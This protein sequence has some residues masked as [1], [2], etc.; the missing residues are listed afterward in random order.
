MAPPYT[1]APN[2][3][4]PQPVLPGPEIVK[5]DIATAAPLL[6]TT[7]LVACPLEYVPTLNIVGSVFRTAGAWM[8]VAA[9]PAPMIERFFE[10][11]S[12]SV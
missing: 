3:R 5:S 9:L 7:M 12:C 11:T 6:T 10:T 8:T 2:P 4:L 1:A